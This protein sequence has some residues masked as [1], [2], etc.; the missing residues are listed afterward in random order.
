MIRSM[1]SSPSARAV[2]CVAVLLAVGTAFGLHPEPAGLGSP[3][4]EKH[5]ASS[6]SADSSGAHTCLACLTCAA[7]LVPPLG[8]IVLAS[9][10]SI[11]AAAVADSAAP[12]RLPGRDLP[13][14]SPPSAS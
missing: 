13:G 11:P 6:A 5:F 12:G 14:R 1:R 3:A 10:L 2:L 8:G 7:A 9:V 4:V